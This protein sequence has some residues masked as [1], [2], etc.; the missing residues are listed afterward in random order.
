[1]L[2]D[3]FF[4]QNIGKVMYIYMY[5][6]MNFIYYIVSAGGRAMRVG[7]SIESLH[8]TTKKVSV[9]AVVVSAITFTVLCMRLR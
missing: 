5:L 2:L 7:L 4:T 1:M 6:G 9:V 8:L 3:K